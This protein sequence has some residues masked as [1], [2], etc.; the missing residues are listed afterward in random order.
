MSWVKVCLCVCVYN[1][2]TISW[3]FINIKT[4]QALANTEFTTKIYLG[5]FCISP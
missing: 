1:F 5:S 2:E 4:L 3:M